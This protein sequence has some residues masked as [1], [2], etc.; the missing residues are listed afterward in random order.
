MVTKLVVKDNKKAPLR[1][2]VDLDNFKN[3]TENES[4][5]FADYDY[6]QV[7]P[8][9]NILFDDI[10]NSSGFKYHYYGLDENDTEKVLFYTF[11]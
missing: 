1:Y 7:H 2:L 10:K 6:V 8:L 5:G 9:E 4:A 3:G 11:P